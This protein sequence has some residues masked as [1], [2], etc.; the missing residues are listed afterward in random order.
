VRDDA[1][2]HE[3]GVTTLETALFGYRIGFTQEEAI[4]GKF[5]EL[6]K[7]GGLLRCWDFSLPETL[8]DTLWHGYARRYINA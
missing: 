3:G 5:G 6:A 1:V 2:L 8:Q 4:T 7:T